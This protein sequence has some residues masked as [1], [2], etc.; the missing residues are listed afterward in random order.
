MSVREK[1]KQIDEMFDRIARKNKENLEN[2]LIEPIHK[3]FLFAQNGIWAM[4]AGMGKGKTRKYLK[5]IARQ[6]VIFEEPI[7]ETVVICSTSSEFDETVIAFQEVI[8]QSNLIAVEDNDLLDWI[9]KYIAKVLIYR[10]LMKF[11]KK[12]LKNP[13]KKMQ[14]LINIHKLNTKPKLIEFIAKTLTEIGW[15]SFP[16]KC[17]LIL[18]DFASHPLLKKREDSLSRTLKKLRH[19]NITVVICVQT[20][21]S[22]PKDLKRNLSDLI[23]FPGI[24]EEDYIHLIRESSASCFD[25]KKLWNEYRKI[26]DKHTSMGLH[27]EAHKVYIYPSN[28]AR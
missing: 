20:V 22:I 23:V 12:N 25:Y 16:H 10:A 14:E 13:C 7:Y 2:A 28:K 15:K 26:K 21:K 4:I 27:I 5:L 3:E 24:S 11:V 19:F 6:E 18:D 1:F 17:L 9:D 8:K